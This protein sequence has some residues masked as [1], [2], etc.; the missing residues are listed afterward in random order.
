MTRLFIESCRRAW[1]NGVDDDCTGSPFPHIEHRPVVS[2]RPNTIGCNQE[3]SRFKN[4][5]YQML[6]ILSWRLPECQQDS[7]LI[8]VQFA[9]D[10]DVAFRRPRYILQRITEWAA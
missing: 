9:L 7:I 2:F 10:T 5:G 8:S 6:S 4:Y 3:M 1:I